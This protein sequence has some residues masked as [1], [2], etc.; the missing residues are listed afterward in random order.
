[1]PLASQVEPFYSALGRRL[2]KLRA[3]HRWSQDELGQKLDPPMSRASIANIEMGK[4][5]VLGHTIEQFAHILSVPVVALYTDSMAGAPDPA[6]SVD[7]LQVD[8]LEAMQEL[9]EPQARRLAADVL[10]LSA[11]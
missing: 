4:Q 5:R 10:R 9:S 11:P 3:Q 2:A 8:L 7:E 6:A 1:M